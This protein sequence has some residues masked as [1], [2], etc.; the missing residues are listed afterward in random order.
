MTANT[1][2]RRY[3]GALFDVVNAAGSLDRARTGLAA[4]ATLIAGHDELR[5]VLESP[6]V[7]QQKKRAL[8]DALLTRLADVGVEVTRLVIMLADRDRLALVAA[9]AKAFDQRVMEAERVVEARI[10]TAVP[11]DAARQSALAR[12]LGAATGREASQVRIDAR[13]DPAILGGVVAQVGSVIY[14]GSVAG[15]IVRL[16]T[17]LGAET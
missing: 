12:A 9:I 14:D 3:A 7:P 13:V 2:A 16:K 1:A 10:T 11:I 15:Q 5:R 17:R 8:L 6:A 4:V